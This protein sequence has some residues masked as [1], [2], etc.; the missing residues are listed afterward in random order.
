MAADLACA[1]SGINFGPDSFDLHR[2]FRFE[3]WLEEILRSERAT[4]TARRAA[5]REM[6]RAQ[7]TQ[8]R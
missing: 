7:V 1:I 5:S 3:K 8:G 2:L 6:G 4:S